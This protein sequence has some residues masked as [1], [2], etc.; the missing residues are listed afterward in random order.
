MKTKNLR[1][2]HSNRK[3]DVLK[4]KSGSHKKTLK[5]N[6]IVQWFSSILEFFGLLLLLVFYS[7]TNLC[8][9]IWKNRVKI[10]K[11]LWKL[12]KVLLIIAIICYFAY[13]GYSMF[14]LNSNLQ[15]FIES[16][17]NELNDEK[18]N[19]QNLQEEI[20]SLKQEIETVKTSKLEE[21]QK[22]EEE[23]AKKQ[24]AIRLAKA[25]Q[26]KMQVTSRGGSISRV[27]NSVSELQAYAK[28]LC[29]NTYG[30]SE[31]DFECLVKLWNKESGWNPNAHNS[32]SGAHGI[33]QSL[34]AS[35]M[36]S[37]GSDYYTN[38]QTQI[39]W[40]LKYIKNRYGSP[41]SAW[42]FWSSHN[43]Y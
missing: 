25:E 4:K 33:P 42:S 30:W 16:T 26:E 24:E 9:I 13:I 20:N 31:N 15:T 2:K 22:A 41:S 36:S 6:I 43:W 19:N 5:N 35:K 17:Y 32:S 29:L 39:R 14:K 12:L 11:F 34:P 7:I 28:N 3:E 27:S 37:E 18:D 23:E 10:V 21:K 8:S 40:G 38:G 1:S